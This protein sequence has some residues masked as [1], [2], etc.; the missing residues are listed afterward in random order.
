MSMPTPSTTEEPLQYRPLSA[1][2]VTGLVIS[3]LYSAIILYSALRAFMTGDPL[4]MQGFWLLFPIVGAV[5]SVLA[6]VEIRR[7]EGTRAGMALTRWG[8]GL[9]FCFGLGYFVYSLGTE[10]AIR[11]QAN[12]FVMEKGDESGFLPLLQSGVNNPRD[13]YAAF[14][15]TVT[16]GGRGK[17]RPEN[18]E[19]ML[20]MFGQPEADGGPGPLQRFRES[21]LT[22]LFQSGDPEKTK[23][24]PLGVTEWSYA[25]EGFLI[26]RLYRITTEELIADVLVTTKSVEGREGETRRWYVFQK[27]TGPQSK[28]PTDLGKALEK[29]RFQVSEHL[30]GWLDK[31]N[32]GNAWPEYA[33]SLNTTNWEKLAPQNSIRTPLKES[34]A[35]LFGG[36]GPNRLILRPSFEGVTWKRDKGKLI[37][38]VPVQLTM[39]NPSRRGEPVMLGAVIDVSTRENV[40]TI[41]RSLTPQWDITRFEFISM[42]SKTMKGPGGPPP[43]GD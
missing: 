13:L 39:E 15:L 14:L 25:K 41:D 17:V 34:V 20:A 16:P 4:L 3:A 1:L 33:S 27:E 5:L 40:A 37:F 32:Q 9:S 24:E 30:R 26:R 6:R 7:S 38:T 28:E 11:Q 10:L 23:I 29:L 8:L 18:E 35:E 19:D 42:Q 36:T 31:L 12:R 22:I 21:P 43:A 2:A